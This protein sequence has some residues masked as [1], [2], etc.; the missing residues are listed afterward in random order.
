M[1][2]LKLL[3]KLAI[4]PEIWFERRLELTTDLGLEVD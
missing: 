4:R 3:W 1:K 2:E